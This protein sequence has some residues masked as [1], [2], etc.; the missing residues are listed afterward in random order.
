MKLAIRLVPLVVLV[1]KF[2][3][4]E[5]NPGPLGV[6]FRSIYVS[7]DPLE[8]ELGSMELELGSCEMERVPLWMNVAVFVLYAGAT[9]ARDRCTAA[10]A[11][12]Y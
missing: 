12:E 8:L 3:P 9:V 5:V 1:V 7:L 10:C 2:G 6:E 11:H 4:Y